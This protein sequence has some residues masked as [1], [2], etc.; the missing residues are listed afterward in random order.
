V[1]QFDHRDPVEN[2]IIAGCEFEGA[3]CVRQ[4]LGEAAE[5]V[6]CFSA[7]Q[8]KNWPDCVV[9]TEFDRPIETCDRF[10]EPV[11]LSQRSAAAE[12]CFRHIGPDCQRAVITGERFLAPGEPRQRIAAVEVELG[13]IG[14]AGERAIKAI[15]RRLVAAQGGQCIAAVCVRGRKIR[16]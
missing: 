3:L 2:L 1:Q 5:F 9:A 6:Q 13:E 10:L 12:F 15:D 14:L 11:L 8:V 7:V 4:S 16:S